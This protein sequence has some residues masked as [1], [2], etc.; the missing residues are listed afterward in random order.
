[1]IKAII[2]DLDDTLYP[3]REAV[4]SGF[5]A[6][7]RY[8][9]N[10]HGLDYNMVLNVLVEGFKEG[11]RKKNFDIF[12]ENLG[13][14][15]ESIFDLVEIYR[16]HNPI[17]IFLYPDAKKVLEWAKEKFKIGLI[18]N[19]PEIFQNNKISAL[20]IR[21]YFDKIFISGALGEDYCKP[22]KKPYDIILNKLKVKPEEAVYVGDNPLKDFIG[23]R[24]SG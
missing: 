13:I 19:G 10:K 21:E 5:K 9:S 15:D 17:S 22:S 14:E 16:G 2:F 7:S 20:G 12:L 24:E 11:L 6:V 3:E 8:I 1:M 4:E 23:A 18:T